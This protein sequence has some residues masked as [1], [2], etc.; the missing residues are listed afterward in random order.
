[1]SG[2]MPLART[3]LGAFG[4]EGVLSYTNGENR[5]TGDDL[6]NVVPWH[7]TLTLTHQ[8]AGWSNA[9]D[10]ELVSRKDDVSDARNEIKT[11][12]YGLV[13]LRASH[14]W[15]DVRLDLGVENLF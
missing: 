6:Y 14:A 4:F 1:L 2:K 3:G 10:W 11:P 5:D 13:H 15:K 9:L 7:A 8:L 12:G